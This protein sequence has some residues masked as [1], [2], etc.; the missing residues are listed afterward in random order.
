MK[1][2]RLAVPAI[3]L[4]AF[5]PVA[6]PS[7]A[8]A[9]EPTAGASAKRA[10]GACAKRAPRSSAAWRRCVAGFRA[11]TSRTRDTT[12][13]TVSWKTPTAGATV[14]GTIRGSACEALAGDNRGV[15][16]VVMKVDGTTLNTE[17][18]APWNCSFDS[19]RVGDGS[20]TLSATA[21]DAAGNSR[22]A[23]VSINVANAPAP[24]PGPAPEPEPE[25]APSGD[26]TA[27]SVSWV[28]P[29]PGATVGGTLQEDGCMATASDNAGVASVVFKLDGT[30]IYTERS[31]PYDCAPL[32]TTKLADGAHTLTAT[33]YD[34][35]GN[36]RTASVTVNAVN[37]PAPAP[38]PE[39]APSPAPPSSN[40]LVV[41]IDGGWGT[42]GSTETTHR[43]QLGAAVTRH[44]WDITEPVYQQD[45]LVLKAAS[46]IGTRIHALLGGN[47]LGNATSYREFVIGFVRRYGAGGSFWDLHPELDE[48]RYAID[49]IELGN[50]PYFG[51]M[52]ASLYADT[53]RP[54]LE[55]IKRLGLPVK[56]V[57]AQRVYGS[58]T[59]WM[60]TL[61]TR[62]PNLNSLFYAFAEHPYWYAHDP[63]EV[64]SA[65]PFRRIDKVRQRM[66]EKGAAEKSIFLTEYGESTALCATECVSEAVQAEH[67]QKMLN[68]V[69]TR[70]YW[71]VEMIAVFQLLDRGTNSSDREHGFGILRQNGSQKPVYSFVRGLMQTYRG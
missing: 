13:P 40:S 28:A 67:L 8:A 53:V 57:L 59:S 30:T 26:T 68:A 17:S 21:Y 44:E 1:L 29:A 31:A 42:W 36:S 56:V 9:K 49:T 14:K 6:A 27:P 12:A 63:A 46:Q 47:S 62:I 54:T 43:A 61:Y 15:S 3:A 60:D 65:G 58:D 11:S 52:S 20:H 25:P 18:S 35:A 7:T 16:R 55:E 37:A 22:T 34:V 24:A 10:A 50:E 32:D 51:A 41:A 66:N 45:A 69:I 2:A 23:S 33:A 70:D 71:N 5:V 38:A 39:P 48:S 64:T 19:T 4:A